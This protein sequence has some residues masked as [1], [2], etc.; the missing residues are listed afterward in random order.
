VLGVFIDLSKAFDKIDHTIM[1]NKLYQYGVRGVAHKWFSSYLTNRNQ[2]VQLTRIE[3]NRSHTFC[4]K[5]KEITRGV[6]QGS[7]LG[8]ILFVIY[9]NDL[10]NALNPTKCVLYADDVNVIVSD[11]NPDTLLEKARSTVSMLG[12]WLNENNLV[13]NT[14][15]TVLMNFHFS[16][17][18]PSLP[19][20][21]VGCKQIMCSESTKLLGIHIDHD[22]SWETHIN[23][24]NKKLS[25]LCF[26][27]LRLRGIVSLS[28]LLSLYYAKVQSLLSFGII[29][30]G[31]AMCSQTIFRTQKKILRIIFKLNKRTSCRQIFKS[32]KILTLPSL[33]IYN[34]I[35]FTIQ[36]KH[37]FVQTKDIHTHSTRQS[38]NIYVLQQNYSKFQKGVYVKCTRLYNKLPREYKNTSK[39]D[40]KFCDLLLSKA[41]YSIEE[42]VNDD[43]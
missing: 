6:P 5:S 21:N 20:L 30:W 28:T 1:L 4:S 13:L 35:K 17:S 42:F 14:D 15:K 31:S 7:I 25:S 22:I 8:P 36:N 40:R 34:S 41:Y 38:S 19:S 43:I 24:L 18:R 10:I 27:F 39:V 26:A 37:M 11:K 3:A 12:A 16:G 9:I 23:I 29:F 32:H 33:Y 2:I